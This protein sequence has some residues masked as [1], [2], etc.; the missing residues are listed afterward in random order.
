MTG[1]RTDSDITESHR[2]RVSS[3]SWFRVELASGPYYGNRDGPWLPGIPTTRIL[4]RCWYRDASG[5]R[6]D[7]GPLE[8]RTGRL[9]PQVRL[10]ARLRNQLQVVCEAR[11]A[12]YSLVRSAATAARSQSLP[13]ALGRPTGPKLGS[14]GK[15]QKIARRHAAS[16]DC[17]VRRRVLQPKISWFC[18]HGVPRRSGC[19]ACAAYESC[20]ARLSQQSRAYSPL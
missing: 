13:L 7:G 14:T 15:K 9:R 6:S 10:G 4:R 18:S 2:R 16:A 19:D 11:F 1:G 5:N 12:E 17:R 20:Q 8:V 3:P